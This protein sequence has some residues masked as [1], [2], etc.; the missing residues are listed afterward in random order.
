MIDYFT[1]NI[2]LVAQA[3]KSF[4]PQ[5]T[6]DDTVITEQPDCVWEPDWSHTLFLNFQVDIASQAISTISVHE[7]YVKVFPLTTD[8]T[9][10]NYNSFLPGTQNNS[11]NSTVIQQ[12]KLNRSRNFTQQDIQ[13]ASQ[14]VN[15][16]IVETLATTTQQS[17]SPNLT[18]PRPENPSLTQKT[19]QSTVKPS[20]AP[21]YSHMD[22]QTYRPM[23]KPSKTRKKFTRSNFA[24]H[25]YNYVNPSQTNQPP[26]EIHKINCFHKNGFFQIHH[27]TQ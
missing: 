5:S 18:T 16:E 4:R 8:A 15:E 24:E 13:I 12:E 21:K 9:P 20:V 10:L 19:I 6:N 3:R 26:A 17:I 22:Y 11:L 2:D 25:D 27:K 7:D 14:V 23:T 1:H